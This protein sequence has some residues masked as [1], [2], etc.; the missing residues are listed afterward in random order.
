MANQ[1]PRAPRR[2]RITLDVDLITETT[3]RIHGNRVTAASDAAIDAALTTLGE[4]LVDDDISI[5]VEARSEWAYLWSDK[6]FRQT[7]EAE[8]SEEI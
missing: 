7:L 8:S 4:H 1:S 6:S 2:L 5:N 3:R